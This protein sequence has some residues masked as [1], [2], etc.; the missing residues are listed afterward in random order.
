[1]LNT[2]PVRVVQSLLPDTIMLGAELMKKQGI[3]KAQHLSLQF[4]IFKQTIK[5]LPDQKK[6]ALTMHSRL[7]QQLAIPLTKN[8]LTLAIH[9]DKEQAKLKLGPL[10]AVLINKET[11]DD[12]DRPFGSISSFCSELTAACLKQ[13][14]F[15][16]FFTPEALAGPGTLISGWIQDGEWRKLLLPLAEVI[17]N[18][19]P[20]RKAESQAPVQ[21]LIRETARF[22]NVSIFNERFLDKHE[23]F[24]LLAEDSEVADYLPQSLLLTD[25]EQLKQM[26]S[27][28]AVLYLK[29]IHGSMGRGIYRITSQADNSYCLEQASNTFSQRIS[30]FSSL[31]RLYRVLMPKLAKR[32]YQL[33]QGISIIQVGRNPVDFRA[34]VQK[35]GQGVWSITSIVARTAGNEQFVSNVARGGS[36]DSVLSTLPRSNLLQH[37]HYDDLLQALKKAALDIAKVI[38]EKLEEHFAELGVDLAVDVQGKV[39]LI[40]VNSKP[41]KVDSSTLQRNK[42]RPSVR[43]LLAYAKYLAGFQEGRRSH[44]QSKARRH[45]RKN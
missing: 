1:M 32:N 21:K 33:Q 12:P 16:Y 22:Y 19:L 42:I 13:G 15:V 26:I 43:M 3:P 41:S 11:P 4:G 17:Y 34:L 25:Y 40:E 29:P 14:A 39:W 18:R 27:K 30:K 8:E 2:V 38:D 6:S 24:E 7:A 35:N 45:R 10:L 23:V 5:V 37:I 28:H 31:K 20:S 44:E 36:I 9:Y